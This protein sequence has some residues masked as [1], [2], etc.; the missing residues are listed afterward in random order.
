MTDPKDRPG[1][2][3]DGAVETK[4]DTELV[5]DSAS[6]QF[7]GKDVT[8][9]VKDDLKIDSPERVVEPSLD[10]PSVQFFGETSIWLAWYWTRPVEFDRFWV[11]SVRTTVPMSVKPAR[12]ATTWRATTLLAP[13]VSVFTRRPFCTW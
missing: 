10:S 2:E 5:D 13:S 9:L 6:E 3:K 11:T 12:N 4:S 1:D 8:D 7:F